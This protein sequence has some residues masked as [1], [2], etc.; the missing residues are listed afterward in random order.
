MTDAQSQAQDNPFLGVLLMLAFCALI[1]LSDALGKIL[2]ATLP[3]AL[4]V[5]ARVSVQVGLLAPLARLRGGALVPPRRLWG[6]IVL[7]TLLYIGGIGLMFTSLRYLPLADAVAIAFVMPFIMLLLGH[8]FLGEEV[9][10]R[11]VIACAVGFL[12]TLMVIQPSFADVGPPALLPVGVA[13]LFAF[14]MLI[15]RQIAKSVEPVALQA[16]TGALAALVLVPALLAGTLFGW[17]DIR[18]VAVD[19]TEAWMLLAMAIIGSIAHL[20]MTW[21]LRLAPSAT[22]APMQYLE[23]PFATIIGY[24]IFRDLPNGLAA[25][26]IIVTISAGLYIIAR[27]RREPRRGQP[28]AASPE[29]LP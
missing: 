18:F 23:I 10:P 20:L 13:V 12:G 7:R 25:L 8:V 26:G 5:L 24:F 19:G 17:A 16:I 28:A 6:V 11:R 4:I 29:R 2:G 9:G 15:T 1:P 27:E 3:I 14:F 21:S 22:L